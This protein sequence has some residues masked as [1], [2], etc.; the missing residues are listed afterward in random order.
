MY[1]RKMGRAS[2][3]WSN[4]GG[5][6]SSS[7]GRNE[8]FKCG[9]PGHWARDCPSATDQEMHGSGQAGGDDSN[10]DYI[11]YSYGGRRS[12]YWENVCFKCGWPGHWQHECPSANGGGGNDDDSD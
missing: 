11:V 2:S 3:G 8:C 9:R 10:N 7:A 1:V 4:Y 5:G 6:D 12:P